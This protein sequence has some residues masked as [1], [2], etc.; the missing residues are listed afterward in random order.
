MSQF[1]FVCD[2]EW[3]NRLLDELRRSI[4]QARHE[5]SAAGWVASEIAEDRTG[6]APCIALCNQCLPIAE[7]IAAKSISEWGS[8]AAERIIAGLTEHDGPWRLHVFSVYHPGGAVGR[9]RCELIRDNIVSLLRKKHRRLLRTL[10]ADDGPW[11]ADEAFAQVALITATGGYVSLCDRSER[12][13]FR[14]LI[15]PFCGGIAEVASD[16]Q[17]PS[18]AFAKLL[19]AE[20]RLGRR[21]ENGESCVDL[22]SS[23]GSWAY[24]AMNR[25]ARVV[26]VDRSPLCADL[27][28]S[29]AV[30]FVRGDAFAYR[31]TQRFDWLL[32]D[33]I[34]A[35]E[36]IIEL[37]QRWIAERRC[38]RFCVTIKFRGDSE[39][40]L[41]EPLK[42]WLVEAK[43]EFVLRRLTNNKNEVTAMGQLP[44]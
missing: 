19:E 20:I 16:K 3:E 23:P 25:G 38:R 43:V 34:A 14:Q 12:W 36:R 37:L 17:A 1:V 8:L 44:E 18:R 42:E 9:R 26:A 41:L 15:A 10:T 40:A 28:T 7:A 5:Q 35:P 13:K 24:V 22:G 29:S 11:Q 27:M 2:P 4:P 33:V 6:G 31:P 32:C 39:Y 30:A 21:I